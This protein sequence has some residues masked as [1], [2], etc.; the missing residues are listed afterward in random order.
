MVVIY[1]GLQFTNNITASWNSY[2]RILLHRESKFCPLIFVKFQTQVVWMLAYW[3]GFTG[4]L[5]EQSHYLCHLICFCFC[6]CHKKKNLTMAPYMYLSYRKHLIPRAKMKQTKEPEDMNTAMGFSLLIHLMVIRQWSH[7]MISSKTQT[8]SYAVAKI[9]VNQ[10]SINKGT[11][12]SYHR[13]FTCQ[14]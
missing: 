1:S 3:L 10:I 11:S 8:N 6:C 5:M 7:T 14:W 2:C 4:H 13:D 12:F 9:T